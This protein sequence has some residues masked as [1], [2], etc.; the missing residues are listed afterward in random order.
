MQEKKEKV[1][2]PEHIEQLLKL[3]NDG[4]YFKLVSLT[5]CEVTPGHSRVEIELGEK[6]KNTFGGLHG[7]VFA[8]I[9]D[10][11]AF[12]SV[13]CDVPEEAG[14]VSLDL[15]VDDLSTINYGKIIAEGRRIKAGKS[16]CLS[17][18]TLKHESGKLLAHGVSKL[19]ITPGM[20]SISKRV[21]EMGLPELPPKF[22]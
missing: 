22:L 12:W 1:I 17:D 20:Q 19:M 18:V 14:H 13:Y 15:R 6:H 10:T 11:A 8:T 4:A 5:V 9:V 16:V 2:N 7:G 21:S 3:V